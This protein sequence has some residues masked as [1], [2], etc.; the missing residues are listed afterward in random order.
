ML[1][2]TMLLL[3]TGAAAAGAAPTA[4]VR[5]P[6]LH[7]GAEVKIVRELPGLRSADSDTYLRSD[8]TRMIKTYAAPINYRDTAGAWTPIKDELAQDASGAWHPKASAIPVTLPASLGS[9][10]VSFG[11]P[12]KEVKLSLQ[13]A[14]LLDPA[15]ASGDENR[16][17]EALPGVEAAY[18]VGATG[19][20]DTLTLANASAPSVYR[21]NLSLS[22]GMKAV[23]EPWGGFDIEDAARH[24]LYR[25]A[26]PTVH[27]AAHGLPAAGKVH[28]ELSPDGHTLSLMLDR[29]WLHAPGRVFPVRIDPDLNYFNDEMDCD[30]IS[31]PDAGTSYCGQM[32]YV[33]S[34]NEPATTAR[35]LMRFDL[36]DIP[37][38]SVVLGTE[39]S[40][41]FAE[42]SG[43]AAQKIQA[44]GLTKKF[45][46]NATWESYDGVHVWGSG[47]GDYESL[48]LPGGGS[49]A[50]GE[51]TYQSSE[52][53]DWEDWP[54]I[55]ITPLVQKW[56]S[57]P[58][59]NDGLLLKDANETSYEYDGFEQR[60][61]ANDAGAALAVI[62]SPRVGSYGD[63][64]YSG[65]SIDDRAGIAVNVANGNLLAD[66][67]DLELPGVGYNYSLDNFY[68]NED[69]GTENQFGPGD[70]YSGDAYLDLE[71]YWWDET[72]LLHE[73]SGRWVSFARE[74]SADKEGR[75]AY[76]SP[77]GIN[78]TMS[79]SASNQSELTYT[80]S[81]VKYI[82][83]KE[84]S[85]LEKIVDPNGNTTK[86]E[87]DGEGH[88]TKVTDT[89]GHV[90]TFTNEGHEHHTSKV[91]D[92]LGRVWEFFGNSSNQLTGMS[93]PD[94]HTLQ[95]AYDE[96]GDLKQITDPDGHL[97]ELSYNEEGRVT[98]IRRVVNGTATTTGNKDVI[99]TFAYSLPA[100]SELNCPEKTIGD[101]VVV[102]PDGSPNGEVN[103]KSSE[104]KTTY[105]FNSSD[106]ITKTIDQ[107]GN[108]TTSSYNTAFGQ[109]TKFQNP[110]DTSGGLNV[111]NTI[112]YAANGAVEKIVEGT[113][114]S[115]S[116]STT[117]NYSG[118]EPYSGVEPS[119]VQTP[120]SHGTQSA[121]EHTT[122]YG[123]DEHGN[124]ST[125]KQG[126]TGPEAK[127]TRN[128]LGQPTKSYDGD[129]H[130]TEYKYNASKDLEKIVPPAPLGSTELTYDSIDRVH[131]VKDG[132]GN[133]ETY[134]YDGE[135]RVTKVEYSDGS[136]VS[137]EYDANGN[138]IKRTD[139][140][141]FGEPY[142]GVTTYEY[143]KL[144][145]PTL[146]TLP[147][148]KSN[149][150][151]YDYDGNLTSV[152]DA[153]GT[154]SY[155]YGPDDLLASMTDPSNSAHPYKFGY[156]TGDDNRQSIKY[157]NGMLACYKTDAAG[158][159]TSLRVFVA[160]GSQN[161]SSSVATSSELEDYG[162]S[163][164]MEIEKEG[165]KETIETP[166]VQTLKNNKASTQTIFGYDTLDRLEGAVTEPIGGGTASLTSLYEYD[167]AGNVLLNHTYSPTTTY[168]NEHM[169]YNNANE[170]C[171]IA[172]TA[173]SACASPSEPGIAGDPTYD[174]DGDMT[175]DGSSAPAKFAYTVRDQL[176]KITPHEG[177][178]SQVVSHGTGQQ[179]LAAV[180]SEEVVQNVL[181]VGATGTG[182]S[183]KY[184]TRDASGQ[185][186]AR[187]TPS[188]TPSE[189]QYYALD[190]LGSVAMT[191]S[192]TGVQVA[193]SGGSYQYDLYGNPI[194][195]GPS[196]FGYRSGQILPD[197]LIH[198]GA[199]YYDPAVG[200]WTQQ[201]P[202][203]QAGSL[204]QANRYGYVGADPF[205]GFDPQ[206][207]SVGDFVKSCAV[208]GGTGAAVNALDPAGSA[209][210]GFAVGCG[211]GLV[212]EGLKETGHETLGTIVEFAGAGKDIYEAGEHGVEDLGKSFG[213]A[214]G[215]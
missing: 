89:H 167:K 35:A 49:Q 201:D 32:L 186:L 175:S 187:R 199:R 58:S 207:E 190:P 127:I 2:A 181:G 41:Y 101:T 54:R 13:G 43:T 155:T 154:V 8:G 145:R 205:N 88:L 208:S 118:S 146:E 194:G 130:E 9:G 73:A 112:S 133:T 172:T 113:G 111:N 84:G 25:L 174:A 188:G 80:L 82:F 212:S 152:K 122:N 72:M 18:R 28:Y 163:Y 87:Y 97:I 211:E 66:N 86:F 206:G 40:M 4:D 24:S 141:G 140:G 115:T 47:G 60:E 166:E 176:S 19:L 165:K 93:D 105:C 160:S 78:A 38:D 5:N 121:A 153:G 21:Y 10:A 116:L 204:T 3:A 150:Y 57:E 143:D 179:D 139:A 33:G 191:T 124:V 185:L 197:G 147:S 209:A 1:I 200:Q 27:D 162:L 183:A 195:T 65:T 169:K 37:K 77:A 96:W 126:S 76:V 203:N 67:H 102:S 23:A 159:T 129:G 6:M 16:Y 196:T 83:Q 192:S 149:T 55:G 64:T 11:S 26:P 63:G 51:H 119:S 92:G 144:N 36:S 148:G 22:P 90:L 136:S 178:A 142:T 109:L 110:G 184:Y 81:R 107:S 52:Y 12:G 68:N 173:P 156:D 56:V 104:H 125:I 158:R 214:I 20:R 31:G 69:R 34:D 215:L 134:T 117:F 75:R 98:K 135:D 29:A 85:L 137:F 106:E 95:Y 53:K 120:R 177:G 59:S 213:E 171:A 108:S 48:S 131:T 74:P 39:I 151:A 91:K 61:G 44:Y 123:Y 114:E 79:I 62:Y 42:R 70:S 15:S 14:G 210:S 189:T 170:I 164:T 17:P 7:N 193:P 71:P 45:T 157:P 99:T 94:K 182:E 168:S 103:S 100:N 132:R 128:G 30:I 138:V 50:F 46:A 198:F 202:I 180:G 161:C